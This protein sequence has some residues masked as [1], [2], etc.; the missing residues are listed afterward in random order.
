MMHEITTKTVVAATGIANLAIQ[1]NLG[2]PA[3]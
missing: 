2:S 1:R 3:A